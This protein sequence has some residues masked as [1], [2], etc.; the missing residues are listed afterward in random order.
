MRW[1][2]HVTADPAI[3][4]GKPII[5]G[6]RISIGFLLELLAG[7]WT[8]DQI[9]QGYPHLPGDA[10]PAALLFAARAVDRDFVVAARS[11]GT[12]EPG[13]AG[14]CG[15]ARACADPLRVSRINGSES[16]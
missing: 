11:S 3:V 5:R 14:V 1:Q 6:T 15:H 13:N 10:V 9:R 16:L 12:S 8:T 4:A 2:D 7:G